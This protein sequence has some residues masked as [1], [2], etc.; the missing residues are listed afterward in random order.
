[1]PPPFKYNVLISIDPVGSKTV[2]SKRH[3]NDHQ[4]FYLFITYVSRYNAIP[5]STGE[6]CLVIISTALRKEG[7]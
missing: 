5:L 2:N 6:L 3:Q 4:L 1:M 7:S